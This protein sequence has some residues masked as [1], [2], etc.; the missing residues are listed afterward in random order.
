MSETVKRVYAVRRHR[1]DDPTLAFSTR[2]GAEDFARDWG[3][4]EDMLRD[5][6][7]ELPV[8]ESFEALG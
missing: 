5:C 6:V 3:V 1:I 2:E 4:P 8:F 7:M